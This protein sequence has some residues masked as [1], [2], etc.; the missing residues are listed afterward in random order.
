MELLIL[1]EGI[2]DKYDNNTNTSKPDMASIV[3][4]TK[5]Q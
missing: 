3:N 1:P 4:T 5:I 2:F